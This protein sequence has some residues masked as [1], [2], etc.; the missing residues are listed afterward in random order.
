MGRELG[1]GIPRKKAARA[2]PA[3]PAAWKVSLIVLNP[4]S[5][6]PPPPIEQDRAHGLRGGGGGGA[7]ESPGSVFP[8][9]LHP[10]Q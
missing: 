8:P 6:P 5:L 2:L 3:V 9:P 4:L 1:K 10:Y 7:Q